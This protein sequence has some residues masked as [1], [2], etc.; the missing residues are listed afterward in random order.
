MKNILTKIL[1]FFLILDI[2]SPFLPMTQAAYGNG[3]VGGRK[4]DGMGIYA[5]GVDLSEWQ[6]GEVDFFKIKEQGYSFVILRAGFSV[7]IDEYF[8]RNYA[9]AKE[10]GLHVGVYLYS[11][12]D[13]VEEVLREADALKGW[14]KGK[15]LEYPV[16]YDMEEPETHGKMPAAALTELSMS[17]LN[18]MAD[19]GWLVGLYSCKSW[20]DSKLET[21]KICAQYECWMAL[22]LSSGSYATYDRYDEFCGMWQYS[23]TGRVE[24]VPGNVDMNVAFKDYPDICMQFGLNGYSANGDDFKLLNYKEVPSILAVGEAFTVNGV[25]LSSEG[26]L[27]NVTAGMYDPAGNMATGR[28]AGP[29]GNQY[30]LSE[31]SEGVKISQLPAGSYIYRVT[32]TNIKRTRILL[33]RSVHITEAGVL[34]T[35]LNAPKDLALGDVFS[36]EGK[37]IASTNLSNVTITI[38]SGDTEKELQ[39]AEAK[40]NKT[41]FDLSQ[42][43]ID[44]TKLPYG[45]YIYKINAK[46]AKGETVLLEEPFSVWMRED[47]IKLEGFILKEEYYIDE[48]KGLQ[49]TL[50]STNSDFIEV[51]ASVV[52]QNKDDL[53]I[54]ESIIN[55]ERTVSLSAFDSELR[56]HDLRYGSYI[57]K[58]TAINSAGP[59]TIVEKRFVIRSDG[60]SLCDFVPPI[61]LYEGDSYNLDGAVVSDDTTLSMVCV[62][63]IDDKMQV[64]LDAAC[65]PEVMAF[66]LKELSAKLPFGTLKQGTYTLRVYAQNTNSRE[67]LYDSKFDVTSSKDTMKWKSPYRSINGISFASYDAPTLAGMVSSENSVITS[68]RAEVFNSDGVVM[69]AAEIMPMSQEAYVTDLNEILRLAA[70]SAGEYRLVLTGTNEAGCFILQDERFEI[71]DCNHSNVRSGIVH[72]QRCDRIGAVANSRC[73]DCADRVQ[74]GIMIPRDAHEWGANGCIHCIAGKPKTYSLRRSTS[75]KQNGRYLVVCQSYGRYYALGTDGKAVLISE[76][77]VDQSLSA[78]SQLLWTA[79]V[80]G[81]RV[82]LRSKDVLALQLDSSALRVAC[83]TGNSMLKIA[84]EADGNCAIYLTQNH[85]LVFD[86]DEFTV[87][88]PSAVFVLYELVPNRE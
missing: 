6:G 24:G 38:L 32:A 53:V 54:A 37:L 12:A 88:A 22:Y 27:S 80:R 5:H 42:M 76:P 39:R 72:E 61:M 71:S 36:P 11:Y 21:D 40:P 81:G 48:L 62:S 10:A 18:S 15:K 82:A 28:S 35:D 43:T 70:L 34:A 44:L 29:R 13:T 49:G 47:P 30:D 45:S 87:G 85:G 67:Y 9:A 77:D 16:Y 52:D 26:N 84:F 50:I 78:S 14:L 25:I 73:A 17:F 74:H 60:L 56:L 65:V 75:V 55:D 79:F 7:Y 57:F 86:E 66:G 68:I 64:V 51:V 19:D 63:V 1:V 2:L 46:S 33:Q 83:G 23:A 69:N 59:K 41:D 3:Y 4:G 8:E 20:L 58:L 31:L